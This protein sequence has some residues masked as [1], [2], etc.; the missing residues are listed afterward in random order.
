MTVRLPIA[1]FGRL[2]SG[3]WIEGDAMQ[4]RGNLSISEAKR[5]CAIAAG[6]LRKATG[7]RHGRLR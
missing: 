1:R 2:E 7:G 6:A 4:P 5:I 3:W